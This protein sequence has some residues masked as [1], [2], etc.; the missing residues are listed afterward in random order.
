KPALIFGNVWFKT[1][2]G[3]V[4]W[5]SDL[6]LNEIIGPKIDHSELEA[7]YSSVMSKTIPGIVDIVYQKIHPDFSEK[8]NGRLLTDFL[9]KALKLPLAPK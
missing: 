2:P 9:R 4:S 1:L 6:T 5:H 7:T 8:E 3:V